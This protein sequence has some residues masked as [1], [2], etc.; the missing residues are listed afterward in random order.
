MT[1][2]LTP[3]LRWLA[4][5]T[6]ALGC[7]VAPPPTPGVER[8]P[9]PAAGA[10]APEPARWTSEPVESARAPSCA[11]TTKLRAVDWKTCDY[12]FDAGPLQGG[13]ASMHVYPPEGGPHDT[14]ATR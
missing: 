11:T 14:F 2:I 1:T 7:R 6:T 10:S 9:A 12:G 8:A 3:R 5:I 13:T 4:L